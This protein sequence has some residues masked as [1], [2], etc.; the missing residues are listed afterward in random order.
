MGN[1]IARGRGFEVGWGRL[2]LG[3]IRAVLVGG[4]GV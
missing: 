1:G 2:E 3:G 4:D